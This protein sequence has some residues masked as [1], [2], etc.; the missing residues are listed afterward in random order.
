[1]EG[2][3]E[4]SAR[5]AIGSTFKIR[6]KPGKRLYLTRI[7]KRGTLQEKSWDGSSDVLRLPIFKCEGVV[8]GSPDHASSTPGTD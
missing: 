2:E 5:R 1:V 4:L 3:E 8:W 6:R 7:G